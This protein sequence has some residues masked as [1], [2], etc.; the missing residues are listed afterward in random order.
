MQQYLQ[1][2]LILHRKLSIPQLGSF[3][4]EDEPARVDAESGLLF[5]P[6][7]VIRF[8]E[9]DRPSSDKHF[10]RFLAEEMQIDELAAIREFHEFCYA[11]RSSIQ[12][13]SMAS[14]QGIGRVVKREGDVL[15]F[16]PETNLLELLPPVPWL[17]NREETDEQTE[18]ESKKRRHKKTA[19]GQEPPANETAGEGAAAGDEASETEPR[20]RW[21]I[22]AM[23]LG[24]IGVLA[25]LYYYRLFASIL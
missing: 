16:T 1:K 15:G 3:V 9:G 7:P 8:S 14:I 5:A 22:Y 2:F 23:I 6:R 24:G 17:S 4:I 13:N 12:S 19:Y 20:D 11:F 21:W 10:F 18:K 25:L